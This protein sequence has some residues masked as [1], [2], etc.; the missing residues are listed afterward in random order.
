MVG[1]GTGIA[2]FR[3]F[4]EE[5]A[6]TGAT[7]RS[8]LFFGDQ[9]LKTDFLYQT[10]WQQHL[11]SGALGRLDVAFSRDTDRKVYVQHRMQQAAAELYAWLAEGAYFYVCGEAAR[12]AKDVHQT[13]IDI[14]AEHGGKTAEEAEAAVKD[15]QK[16]KRYQRDV[17]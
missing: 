4:I 14:I 10:E 1:P 17:Y 6:A 2:P 8:W 5:R 13:L 16:Q 11:K 15:L 12:M 9:H 7:G 3:A